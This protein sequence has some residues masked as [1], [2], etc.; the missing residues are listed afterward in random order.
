MV[1]TAAVTPPLLLPVAL[2]EA[3]PALTASGLVDAEGDFVAFG[4]LGLVAEA[5]AA[6]EDDLAAAVAVVP[7]GFKEGAGLGVVA[8]AV[9]LAAVVD[10]FF[11]AGV[12]MV[13]VVVAAVVVEAEL[14]TV[15]LV[16]CFLEGGGRGG[17]FL[18]FGLEFSLSVFFT[19]VVFFFLPPS[20]SSLSASLLSPCSSDDSSSDS[21]CKETQR[22]G[23]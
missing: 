18:A 4:C 3:A 21:S 11:G 23:I 14:E 22:G 10:G 2:L 8:F 17:V 12:D 7:P 15:G 5:G 20:S 19:G 9:A 6:E 13:A 16:F 1:A